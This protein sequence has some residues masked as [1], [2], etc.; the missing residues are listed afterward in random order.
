MYWRSRGLRFSIDWISD[1]DLVFAWTWPTEDLPESDR[2]KAIKGREG[3]GM[4]GGAER[5]VAFIAAAILSA[6]SGEMRFVSCR[7]GRK[8]KEKLREYPTC[9]AS[10]LSCIS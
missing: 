4:R 3:N 9:C 7:R 5:R 10:Y 2:H 1:E 8:K 6:G